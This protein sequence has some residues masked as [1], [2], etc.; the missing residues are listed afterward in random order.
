[1]ENI[2]EN[3]HINYYNQSSLVAQQVKDLPLSLWQFESL[4][5]H[6]FHP[7][8]KEMPHATGAAKKKGGGDI[9][10]YN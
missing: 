10:C 6:E 3:L 7:W 9:N 4:L 5:W 2:Q 1:M 8:P